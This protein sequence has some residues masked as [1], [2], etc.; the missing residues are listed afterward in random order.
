MLFTTFNIVIFIYNFSCICI[1][2]IHRIRLSTSIHQYLKMIALTMDINKGKGQK[3][4]T[5]KTT[6][7]YWAT[8]VLFNIVNTCKASSET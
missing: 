1:Y 6:Q 5:C 2:N 7:A 3:Y 4:Y 8:A